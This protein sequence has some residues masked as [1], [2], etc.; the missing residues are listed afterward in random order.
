MNTEARSP[1]S[2]IEIIADILR[3]LRLGPSGRMEIRATVKL[4][5]EQIS[6]YLNWLME[7]ELLEETTPEMG[8]VRYRITKKGLDL[9][10]KIESMQEMLPP[11]GGIDILHRSKL[12]EIIQN[13]GIDNNAYN[14]L[15]QK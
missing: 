15:K 1:R 7:T 14:K 3:F 12:I 6:N 8:Q 4:T 5:G 9:L 11:S 2:N 13:I 10:S